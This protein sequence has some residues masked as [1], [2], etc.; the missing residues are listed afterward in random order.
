MFPLMDP[1]R[2]TAGEAG[3]THGAGHGQVGQT[4]VVHV[5]PGGGPTRATCYSLTRVSQV[6]VLSETFHPLEGDEALHTHE[7]LLVH[8]AV[9]V[10]RPL[11]PLGLEADLTRVMTRPDVQLELQEGGEV[12]LVAHLA[13]EPGLGCGGGGRARTHVGN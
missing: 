1:V 6:E 9:L 5:W 12:H 10:Q 4:E 3:L 13:G 11:V 7:V 2:C 8:G